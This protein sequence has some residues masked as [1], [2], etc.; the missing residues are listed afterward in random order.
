MHYV[1]VLKCNNRDLYIGYSDNLKRRV[2]AHKLG[3]VSST[4]GKRPIELVYYEAYR[5]KRDATKREY[6][7]ITGQQRELLRKRLMHS[8]GGTVAKR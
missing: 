1:Y 8:V 7:L 5:D 4:K 2:I 6:N 3:K